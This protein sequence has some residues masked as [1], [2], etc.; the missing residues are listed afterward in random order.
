MK[1]SPP[2]ALVL[3]LI[4]G[5]LILGGC[6]TPAAST[7]T[8][9]KVTPPAKVAA[10]APTAPAKPVPAPKP[11]VAPAAPVAVAPPPAVALPPVAPPPIPDPAKKA[12]V[13]ATVEHLTQDASGDTLAH[14]IVDS[15]EFPQAMASLAPG[16]HA[17]KSEVIYIGTQP[18]AKG[19]TADGNSTDL[20]EKD[21]TGLVLV[22]LNTSLSK[23]YTSAVRLIKVEAHPLSDGRVRI[24]IRVKN[25]GDKSLP[26][27][28]ACL[29]RMQG[30][31]S[32]D[33]PYFYQLDVPE[34]A[35]RDVFFVSPVGQLSTYTML[36]RPKFV[37]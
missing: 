23:A 18:P 26:T 2:V 19:L 12:E 28:I 1:L 31:K 20:V 4:V 15:T 33:S 30:E 8:P 24:W 37:Y 25:I 21:W 7:A 3:P 29:F 10:P 5:A 22:P 32:S 11:A 35:F 6:T 16:A 27:E 36:V 14:E 9:K 34:Q 17:P 13:L